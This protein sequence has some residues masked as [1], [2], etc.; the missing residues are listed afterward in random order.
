MLQS[1]QQA[2]RTANQKS[3]MFIINLV[4]Q[5]GN[6]EPRFDASTML[7]Y[8]ILYGR[9]IPIYCTGSDMLKKDG[10]LGIMLV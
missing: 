4:P 7:S 8:L 6:Y 10:N 1:D 3:D 9:N 2:G 5:R